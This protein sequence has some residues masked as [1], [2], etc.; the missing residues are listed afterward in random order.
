MKNGLALMLIL[1]KDRLGSVSKTHNT[2]PKPRSGLVG[3]KLATV[4]YLLAR[5]YTS[6]ELC[7]IVQSGCFSI[8]PQENRLEQAM[9]SYMEIYLKSQSH[10]FF[11]FHALTLISEE[12]QELQMN[13]HKPGSHGL[14]L[15]NQASELTFS[16]I[17]LK[18]CSFS[19]PT[20]SWKLHKS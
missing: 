19:I 10:V 5:C 14:F 3:A 17:S 15:Q 12:T 9:T 6:T 7:M 2:K 4:L 11:I 1:G 18:L 16:T 13:T 20:C 8:P